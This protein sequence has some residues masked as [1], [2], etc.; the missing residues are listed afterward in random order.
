MQESNCILRYMLATIAYR[1]DKSIKEM[2]EPFFVFQLPI[3]SKRPV[4]LIRHI[5]SVISFMIGALANQKTDKPS[6]L[7]NHTL[8]IQSLQHLLTQ[9]DHLLE[10]TSLKIEQTI[11]IVQGLVS[12]VLIHVGQI[13]MLRRLYNFPIEWGNFMQARIETGN[14]NLT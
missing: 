3:G 4:E 9:P 1:L 7:E 12:D 6:K 13:A 5:S 2:D 14:V 11:R 8:E 10:S